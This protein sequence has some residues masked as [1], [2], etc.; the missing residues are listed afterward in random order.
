MGVDVWFDQ[1]ALESGDDYRLKIEK[2]IENCSYFVP[3]ISRNTATVSRR[4]FFKEW[5]KAI[6]ESA[7]YP[8]EYPFIQPILLDDTPLDSPGIP[9]EF[10]DRHVTKLANLHQLVEAAKKRIRERRLQRRPA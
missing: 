5:N 8:I 2:N 3:L 7:A 9:R 4:F 10:R 1:S 6:A